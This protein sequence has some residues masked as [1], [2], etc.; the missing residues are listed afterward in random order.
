M[1]RLI[2]RVFL[3]VF[4]LSLVMLISGVAGKIARERKTNDNIASLPSF[5]FITLKKDD[6]HSSEIK[7]GPVLIVRFH[8]DCEH[9]RYEVPEIIKSDIPALV[10]K[11]ILIA[12]DHPDSIDKFLGQFNYSDY[13][14]ITAISDT[15][16]SFRK[17]FG[18]DIVPSN[19]IYDKELKLVKVIAGEVKTETIRKYLLNGE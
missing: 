9:C 13:P 6:F 2:Q 15:S 10:S 17:I 3:I 19:Y 4:S 8:P 18:K 11:V 16:D 1:R 5:S 12:N 7:K 14:S